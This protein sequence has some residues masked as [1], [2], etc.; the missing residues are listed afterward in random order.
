MCC[1]QNMTSPGAY[2]AWFLFALLSVEISD[3][4]Y[5]HYSNN[6]VK[7]GFFNPI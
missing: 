4:F 2:G 3:I 7:Q 1:N 6:T 5:F